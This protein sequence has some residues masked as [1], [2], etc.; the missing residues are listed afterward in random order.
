PNHLLTPDTPFPS[1][2]IFSLSSPH[3]PTHS[4]PSINP[5][6]S[7]THKNFPHTL[8]PPPNFLNVSPPTSQTEIPPLLHPIPQPPP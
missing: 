2:P 1:H 4:T 8:K 3:P 6:F 7:I 5:Y